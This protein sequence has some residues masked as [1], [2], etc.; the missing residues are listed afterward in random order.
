MLRNRHPHQPPQP[1][2]RTTTKTPTNKLAEMEE[3]AHKANKQ[4]HKANWPNRHAH[5]LART[6]NQT[7]NV[8]WVR[9]NW[10]KFA[11]FAVRYFITHFLS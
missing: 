2:A 11:N 5:E 6:P 3:V 7:K 8:T 1:T 4:P 9:T 10:P